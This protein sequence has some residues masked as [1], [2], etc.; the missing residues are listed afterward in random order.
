MASVK[1]TDVISN[2]DGTQDFAQWVAK[3]ELVASLQGIKEKEKFL[4]LFLSDG[5]FQVFQGL[6][7]E[8]QEDYAKLKSALMRAFSIDSSA[9]YEGFRTRSLRFGETVDVYLADLSRLAKLVDPDVGE[10]WLKHAFVAGLPSA[11]RDKLRTT[12]HLSKLSLGDTVARARVFVSDLGAQSVVADLRSQ[13]SR[14]AH[15]QSSQPFVAGQTVN[16]PYPWAPPPPRVE[17]SVVASSSFRAARN[18]KFS[19][20]RTPGR[21][22]K[23]PLKPEVE[24]AI[25]KNPDALVCFRC[26]EL[27]HFARNC[28]KIVPE[29]SQGGAN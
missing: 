29:N 14:P 17:Q 22:R 9:A 13:L 1:F 25:R 26:G 15:L 16:H 7:K 20:E 4:P 5:A 21:Q 11:A 2:F 10:V 24:E 18:A 8:D 23:R 28:E 12:D 3:L 27:G 6:E 19:S